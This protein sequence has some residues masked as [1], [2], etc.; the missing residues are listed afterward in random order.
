MV[1]VKT[2]VCLQLLE[3]SYFQAVEKI[4]T[5]GS[6]YMAASGLSPDKQV[7]PAAV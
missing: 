2:S 4:K 5:N 7:R 1:K 3:E 6:S